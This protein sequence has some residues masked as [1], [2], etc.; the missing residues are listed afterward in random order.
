M[1]NTGLA[2]K[3]P[4]SVIG[5]MIFRG[6]FSTS[7][8][9]VQAPALPVVGGAGPAPPS[10]AAAAGVATAAMWVAMV[11]VGWEWASRGGL[12]TRLP[13]EFNDRLGP[14]SSRA[15]TAL[16]ATAAPAT[17]EYRCYNERRRRTPQ[18]GGNAE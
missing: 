3:S 7:L 10:P 16:A 11:D 18:H 17:V 6:L 2:Y 8:Q 15:A 14:C 13:P 1:Q 9:N 4:W 12:R 5:A